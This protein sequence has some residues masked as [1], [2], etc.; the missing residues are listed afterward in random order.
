MPVTLTWPLLP[1]SGLP[2]SSPE[3]ET[4]SAI[5]KA[6]A[7][8]LIDTAE[9][10]YLTIIGEN[11]GI[12]RPKTDPTNDDLF[13]GIIPV[14]AWQPKTIYFTVFRLL[15][16]A[17][18]KQA[19][20][21][22]AGGRAWQIYEVNPNEFIIEVPFDLQATSNTNASYLHGYSSHTIGTS[23][24]TVLT[25]K[26]LISKSTSNPVGLNL[27][28]LIG[29]VWYERAIVSRIE[30]AGNT[31]FTVVAL[32]GAPDPG[33]RFFVD[34]PGDGVLSHRGDYLAT[35]GYV[36]TFETAAGPDTDTLVVTGDASMDVKP[37]MQVLLS[38][39]SFDLTRTVSSRTFDPTTGKTTVVVTSSDVPGGIVGGSFVL[40]QEEAD[41]ASP[42]T[43]PHS[44]RVYLTGDGAVE[45]VKFYLDL[46][47]RAAGVVARFEFI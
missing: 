26:G 32:P 17:L 9:E 40:P 25:G 15:E 21:V 47:V 33:S 4:L 45:V 27:S 8:M 38:F 22:A 2:G 46:L 28:V 11:F 39:S 3:T 42:V 37:N 1:S 34:V 16:A 14:L 5:A 41:D 29:G 24:T 19:D 6:R 18:G 35:G 44:D 30:S 43:P 10:S 31:Q 12:P 36:G 20:I 23:S 13:R 7:S